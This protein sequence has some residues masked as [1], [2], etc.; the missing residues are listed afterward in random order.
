M[1]VRKTDINALKRRMIDLNIRNLRQLSEIS[2]INYKTL[3]CIMNG[4]E[5]PSADAME[6]LIVAL[7]IDLYEAG[8]V[9]FATN[10]RSA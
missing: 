4:K 10:L 9:F 6:K 8:S 5:Q 1:I 2:H 3:G 7:K